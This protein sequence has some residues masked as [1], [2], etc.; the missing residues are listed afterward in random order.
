MRL[1]TNIE[2]AATPVMRQ[3]LER[4]LPGN[5]EAIRR[6]RREVVAFATNPIATSLLLEGPSG[7]GKSALARLAAFLRW[8][9]LMHAD[10]AQE[11]VDLLKFTAPGQIAPLM[12]PWFVELALTGLVEPLAAAQLFGT[13]KGAFTGAIDREGVFARAIHGGD[14]HKPHVGAQV[15]GGIVFLDEIGDLPPSLQPQLLPVLSGGAF[16]PLGA[17]GRPDEKLTFC[18]TIISATWRDLSKEDFRADLLSRVAGTV[19]RVPSLAERHD[20][21]DAIVDDLERA[22]VETIKKKLEFLKIADPLT[23]DRK[24]LERIS[25]SIAPLDAHDREVLKSTDWDL[26]GNIR[27][28]RRAVEAAL[29]GFLPV[30]EVIQQLKPAGDDAA[31]A[32][33]YDDLLAD[34]LSSRPARGGLVAQVRQIEHERRLGLQD[35]LRTDPLAVRKLAKKLNVPETQVKRQLH[36][37]PRRRLTED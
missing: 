24:S 31:V 7:S 6:L 5:S 30:T 18:G 22:V 8:I 13:V 1:T 28:L 35:R 16:Y 14:R 9:A 21:F 26:Y 27:G 12:M 20:D 33:A 19:I 4:M 32:H 15:T 17:E 34:L 25:A 23:I 29:L 3:F 2:P 10:K 36:Q 11:R 37:L